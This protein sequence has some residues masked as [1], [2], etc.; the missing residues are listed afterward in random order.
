MQITIASVTAAIALI[1]AV[2]SWQQWMVNRERLRLE[3][4]DRRFGVYSKVLEFYQ[5]LLSWEGTE[6]QCDSINPFIT[7]VRESKFLFPDAPAM[8]A[9]LREFSI[10]GFRTTKHDELIDELRRSGD[11]KEHLLQ[12]AQRRSDDANWILGSLGQ[13]EELIAPYLNFHGYKTKEHWYQFWL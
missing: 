9:L 4:Y 1:V 5:A 3:L 10:R 8:M 12:V 11:T 7:A 6:K 2:I 13:L